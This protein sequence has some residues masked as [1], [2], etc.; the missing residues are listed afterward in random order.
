ML[1]QLPT[2]VQDELYLTFLFNEF[3]K[4]FV[5]FFKIEKKPI[6]PQHNGFPIYFT[7]HD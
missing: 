1:D 7:M 4:T 2:Q 5:M 3:I 6:T